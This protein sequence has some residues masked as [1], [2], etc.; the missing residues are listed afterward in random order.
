MLRP[1]G[2]I[3]LIDLGVAREYKD[4]STKDTVA[5]G[6]EGYAPPEQYG[7]AQTDARSDIYAVGA[8]M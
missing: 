7:K 4:K 2:Y 3:K 5:F 6:T 8:T 1:D